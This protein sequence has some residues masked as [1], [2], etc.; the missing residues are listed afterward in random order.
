MRA[1]APVAS[2]RVI[3][4]GVATAYEL[5]GEKGP[6]LVLLP[7]WIIIHA[8]Q[9][10]AQIADLS[11]DCRLLVID[12]RGNGAS[13]RPEGR[14]AYTYE[15]YVADALAVIDFLGI[16]DAV[17]VG[18]SMGGPIA[19]LIA[20]ARPALVR[21][22]VLIAPV[23][24]R[25]RGSLAKAEAMFTSPR[26]VYEGLACHNANYMRAEPEAYIRYFFDAMFPEPHSTKQVEDARAWAA[27]TTADVLVDSRLGSLAEGTNVEQ[28]YGGITC[29]VVLLHGDL[30]AIVPLAEGQKVASL[31][32]AD[33]KVMPNSGHGPHLRHPAFVNSAIRNFLRGTG[34]L[35]LPASERPKSRL[36]KPSRIL[37][38]SSPI[39]LG[40]ARRDLAVVRALREEVPDL[41][42]DWLAQDPVS[43]MLALA[44]ESI[45]PSSRKLKS[46]S[47][48]IEAEAGEHDLDVFQA[49]RR[50]DE[51]LVR[52]FRIFQDAVEEGGYTAVIADEAWEVD[53]FWH[54]HPHLKR[55]SLAWMTDF[56]GFSATREGD[57]TEAMLTADYNREMVSHVE[58]NPLVRDVSIFVG[59]PA[60]VM[61]DA[62]ATDLPTRRRWT[63]DHFSFP[64]YIL[65]DAVPLPGEKADLRDQ[66]GMKAGERLLVVTV[67][68]SGVGLTMIRRVL[69][70][71]PLIHQKHP[72][73]RTLVIT[74]PRIAHAA[75]PALVGVTYRSFVPDLPKLLAAC[76][77]AIVQGGLS[78][79]MELA[80]TGT[81]FI[82]VPLQNHFEQLV[83][84]PSRLRNYAAGFQMSFHEMTP[85]ALEAAVSIELAKAISTIPVERD[86]ARRA[87][88]MLAKLF[89]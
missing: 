50:M 61:D 35:P 16:E 65:G 30:D 38:L 1:E 43:R 89:V 52:N 80:A 17:L 57:R 44:G 20:Y 55:A 85:D 88:A 9:W 18:F 56:V 69:D 21:G 47:Q 87:A 22:I 54:E 7:C 6:L 3:R 32:R 11:V 34:Q 14:D 41:R 76:D 23:G 15:Q 45:H 40:H 25:S 33:M 13:D 19:A 49:L 10:K 36:R 29:P 4:D 31:C 79:C 39:G 82:H 8:R 24:P 42:I 73:L 63:E 26:S 27:D 84:V 48:H 58:Q 2:G 68:G 78:T 46:E 70:A 75:L 77:I 12:G 53:H 62:L 67:G 60:D 28:A 81:P 83:H 59:N 51:I 5:Y 66:L 74:G 72:G 64:G 71:L 37:Y 86:G